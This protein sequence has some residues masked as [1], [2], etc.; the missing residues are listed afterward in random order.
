MDYA[1]LPLYSIDCT[2]HFPPYRLFE[3]E[4]N[5]NNPTG[6]VN[7]ANGDIP[8]AGIL[9]E[10][11]RLNV[12]CNSGGFIRFNER[13]RLC[14]KL[15]ELNAADRSYHFDVR[16]HT[17]VHF[18]KSPM[19]S[20][21][22]KL[23][24]YC[25]N[26]TTSN[27]SGEYYI[28]PS[29]RDAVECYF[30]IHL[31]YG[32]RIS[33]T[34][35]TNNDSAILQPNGGIQLNA[36]G[37]QDTFNIYTTEGVQI[38]TQRINLTILSSSSGSSKKSGAGRLVFRRAEP[39]AAARMQAQESSKSSYT[40]RA[41]N[42]TREHVNKRSTS[43]LDGFLRIME[44]KIKEFSF[45]AGGKSSERAGEISN[46]DGVIVKI[47]EGDSARWSY[48]I[49]DTNRMQ[50]FILTS[51]G[52]TLNIHLFKAMRL[53]YNNNM[54]LMSDTMPG[55]EHNTPITS[56][57]TV[58]L[59]YAAQPIAELVS[60]CDFGWVAMQQFCINAIEVAMSWPDA[61]EYC[62]N[63]S[64]HLASIRNEQ[65]QQIINEILFRSPGYDD[66]NAYWVGGSD[67]SYEGDFRW[68]DGLLFQYTSEYKIS[69]M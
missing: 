14:G 47:F 23:V 48:C 16:S 34:L 3:T 65:Q 35:V 38:D 46:C 32:N 6:S 49:N 37:E 57:P 26:I 53:N 41:Y 33:L 42:G 2:V 9:V 69:R 5:N 50:A 58:Y 62:V 18:H 17:T 45:A 12:P 52:N 15:E 20:L 11:Q 4:H 51:T 63:L 21:S 68:S 59:S 67:S 22:Y 31:P 10:L 24:D 13:T 43:S 1:A 29:M 19:F 56:L 36:A 30:H 39:K 27:Q 7:V 8:P 61:E 28:R 60:S 44:S 25:Y 64:G 55:V 54:S 66:Q 40:L